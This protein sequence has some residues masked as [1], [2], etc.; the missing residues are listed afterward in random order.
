MDVQSLIPRGAEPDDDQA[1]RGLA[2]I[3][4]KS[5]LANLAYEAL[6]NYLVEGGLA[7]GDRLVEVQLAKAL[8]VSRGPIRQA[9]QQL[10][11]EGWVEIRPRMGAFVAHRDKKAAT[12]FF[13]VRHTLEVL[14]AGEA[15]QHR[16]PQDLD[17]FQV[18]IASMK[19]RTATHDEVSHSVD[20]AREYHRDG[21]VRF[22]EILAQSTHNDTLRDTLHVLVKKT[23]WYFSPGVLVH[24]E[25]AWD[26]HEQIYKLIERQDVGAVR[27]LMD[28]HMEHT[29]ASYLEEMD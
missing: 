28:R 13:A 7:P 22:H 9:L 3:G 19:L 24:S 6:S 10:A 12:D 26:E 5:S 23:R 1:P 11:A 27:E 29:L 25:R 15:A 21:S 18:C 20:G 14:A 16:T 2:N 8:G 17:Q 4:D